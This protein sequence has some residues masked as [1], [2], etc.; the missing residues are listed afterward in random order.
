M[1]NISNEL[2]QSRVCINDLYIPGFAKHR[3]PFDDDAV[4]ISTIE[5]DYD[6]AKHNPVFFSGRNEIASKIP[7]KL[8]KLLFILR[9]CLL[10]F[11]M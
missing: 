3:P 8:S 2:S 1:N 7:G 9:F 5:E 6:P 10:L 11:V 4:S